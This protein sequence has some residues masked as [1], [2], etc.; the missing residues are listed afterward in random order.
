[1]SLSG[2]RVLI[3]E[4]DATQ[5]DLLKRVFTHAGSTVRTASD[6][7]EALRLLNDESPDLLV[8]DLMVPWVNGIEVLA[9]VRHH[10]SL[11]TLP[12][13]VTTGSATSAYDLRDFG[14]LRVLHKPFELSS[15]LRAAQKLLGISEG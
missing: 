5:R 10:R 15:V 13:L 6:G 2:I 9:A 7:N 8:M 12:V 11:A 3:V 1:V 14:P 4:D